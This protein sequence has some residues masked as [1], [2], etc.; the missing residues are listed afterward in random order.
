VYNWDKNK[1]ARGNWNCAT[2]TQVEILNQSRNFTDKGSNI[3]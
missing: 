2:R 1:L 3:G